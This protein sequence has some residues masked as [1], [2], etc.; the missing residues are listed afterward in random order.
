MIQKPLIVIV[1]PTAAGK[2]GLSIELALELEGEIVSADSMQIYKYMDIGTAKPTPEEQKGIQHYLIDEVTPDQA[3]SV[4]RY[5]ALADNYIEQIRSKGKLPVMVG[6]TGLYIDSTVR[7]I[8][9]SE[10][11]CD[12]DYR[13]YLHETA[14]TKGNQYLH[15]MLEQVDPLTAHKLHVNDV[16]RIIRAL[17]VYRFTGIPMS[18]HQEES[19]KQPSPYNIAMIGLTMD[20]ALLYERINARVDLMLRQGLV[21]EVKKLMDMGYTEDMT[22]MKGLGYKEIID[23]LKGKTTLE[24][25]VEI[26]K[27]DTRRYA[28]RQ[29]TWFRR[30]KNIYWIDVYDRYRP[31][32][33]DLSNELLK[34]SVKH[35]VG[36][37]VI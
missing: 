28:K 15:R 7:N 26:L 34:K 14:Q 11:V 33:L 37:G 1:G 25:A 6:G 24:E 10:T 35:I 18:K 17:E 36:T 19:R 9:F 23:Y 16:R 20:R 3:F 4:A 32:D 31:K 29:L 2:T 5:K 22:S 30:N 21:D 8:Q 13:R 12:W 27:R